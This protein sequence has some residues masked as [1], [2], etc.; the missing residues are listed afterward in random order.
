MPDNRAGAGGVIGAD[1][2]AKAAP[3]GYTMGLGVSGALTSSVTLNPKLPYDPLK[4]FAPISKLVNSP[5]VLVVNPSLKVN[6]LKELIAL[7]KSKPGQLSYGTPGNGSAMHLSGELLK[8]MAGIDMQPIPYKGSAPLTS[9]LLGGQIEIAVIEL[10]IAKPLMA[11][12][13]L[14]GLAVTSSTRTALASDLPTMAEAGVPGYE[15]LSWLSLLMPAKTPPEIVQRVSREVAAV[16]GDP[17]VRAQITAA[18]AEPAPSTP[19]ELM[20]TIRTGIQTNGALIKKAGIK[21]N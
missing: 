11:A 16:L 1:S 21:M 6:T 5:L 8:E 9:D 18:N 15:M 17:K 12:G 19:E 3:D 4:D 2:I 13:K 20:A 7:A 14:K 10:S